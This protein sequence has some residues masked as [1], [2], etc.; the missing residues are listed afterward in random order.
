MVFFDSE[1]AQKPIIDR[2]M[3]VSPD[4]CKVNLVNVNF[5]TIGP[6][7]WY[8]IHYGLLFEK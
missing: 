2:D 3:T 7:A 1:S 4:Q 8:F 5:S 6:A